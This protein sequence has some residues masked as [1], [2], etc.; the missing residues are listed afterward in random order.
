MTYEWFAADA[1]TGRL[2]VMSAN[3]GSG[4][5]RVRFYVASLARDVMQRMHER[6]RRR[7]VIK[8]ASVP[9]YARR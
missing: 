1:I 5:G 2:M 3:E 4:H 6:S 8:N 9:D 7:D